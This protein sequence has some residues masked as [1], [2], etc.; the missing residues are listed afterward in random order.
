MD[1]EHVVQFYDSGPFLIERVSAFLTPALVAG[2]GVIVILIQSHLEMLEAKLASQGHDLVECKRKGQWTAFEARAL[3]AG[4][5]TDGR[6]DPRQFDA[7]VRAPVQEALS[8]FPAIKAMGE[9]V[10]LLVAEKNIE[11]AIRLEEWW[12]GLFQVH[13]VSLFCA[14]QAGCFSREDEEAIGRIHSLHTHVL[15]VENGSSHSP[16][17]DEKLRDW[18]VLQEK[19]SLLEKEIEARKNTEQALLQMKEEMETQLEDLHKLHELSSRLLVT[20]DLETVLHEVLKAA[21]AVYQTDM[22]SLYLKCPTS[23]GLRLAVR[24]GF[25]NE[26]EGVYRFLNPGEAITGLCLQEKKSIV[27]VDLETDPRFEEYRDI[28][29][30][31]GFRSAHCTPLFSQS[32]QIIGVL[33]AYFR[34]PHP[35]VNREIRMVELHVRQ[36]VTA[37]EAAQLRDKIRE[38]ENERK[39]LEVSRQR[40]AAIVESAFVG[41]IGK[42]VKGTITSW[43]RGA[44]KI[45]G[46]VAEEII[47]KPGLEIIP[48]EKWDD[49]KIILEKLMRGERVEEFDTVRIHKDGRPLYVSLTFSPIYNEDGALVGYSKIVH[50]FTERKRFEADLATS[51]MRFRDMADAAPVFVWTSSPDGSITYF[52]KPWTDFRGRPLEM[53]LGHGWMD[54]LH[55][56]DLTRFTEGFAVSRPDQATLRME[57]R[58]QRFDGVYR[59]IL[60]TVTPRFSNEDE[61]IGFIGSGLDITDIREAEEKLR[62]VQKMEAIGRLAG[63]IAHDFNNLLTVINGYSALALRHVKGEEPLHDY[64]TEVKTSGDR[65]AVLT[66]QLLAYGRKQILAPAIFSLNTVVR[67]MEKMIRHLIGEDILLITDLQPELGMVKADPGQV[68]QIILNLVLNARDAMPQGGTLIITT[69]NEILR[70]RQDEY[71]MDS[72]KGPF[73]RLSVQDSGVG[74]T[75]EVK[76]RIFEPFF[77]T[78]GVGQGTG[79][80]L[81]SVFGILK[82]SGGGIAFRSEKNEGTIFH[83]F[84]PWEH[85][86][87]DSAIQPAPIPE[88]RPH[89]SKETILLIEDEDAVRKFIGY[90]LSSQGYKVLVAKDGHEA[91]EIAGGDEPIHLLL[92]DVVMPVMNGGTLA[93]KMTALHPSIRILFM[94]GHASS[95]FLAKSFMQN[96]S[97]YL[98]KPFTEAQLLEKVGGILAE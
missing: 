32:G 41:I 56:D 91:L 60:N 86:P 4:L 65:A 14:Y 58:M 96:D 29:R 1:R 67:E 25:S 24:F 36:A 78:K 9:M 15:A 80:G 50:D 90:T 28:C 48:R 43:N 89:R 97:W 7:R 10:G 34:Q 51:E 19:A 16:N 33:S 59:W 81:S 39:E 95:V 11:G 79:L 75:P 30:L 64:L 47:G 26:I 35:P 52:N 77:T 53:E 3:L 82:Q 2:E 74:M 5:F 23:E 70:G 27:M 71:A 88:K 66:Q 69:H 84:L 54:A 40:L 44:E 20:T 93:K 55:P 76:E 46:H 72:L 12:N 37:I 68:H 94:S 6:L 8:R 87:E 57:V 18:G 17:R 38:A 92:T 45:F 85:P 22:G 13:P 42:D 49:E 21:M 73:I 62:Q 63:G 98:Q 61:C 31:A 83:V